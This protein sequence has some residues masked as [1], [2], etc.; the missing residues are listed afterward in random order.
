[1]TVRKRARTIAQRTSAAAAAI[2]AFAAMAAA[3]VS[4]TNP[5][6][7]LGSGSAQVMFLAQITHGPGGPAPG[8]VRACRIE[9]GWLTGGGALLEEVMGRHVRKLTETQELE[10]YDEAARWR[11]LR[12]APRPR[13]RCAHTERPS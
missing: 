7:A 11:P 13:P 8:R 5:P 2:G 3:G 6:H 9:Y 4:G 1:M 12:E 10:A